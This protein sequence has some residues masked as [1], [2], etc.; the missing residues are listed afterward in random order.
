VAGILL[1]TEALIAEKPK[2]DKG[3]GG[4]ASKTSIESEGFL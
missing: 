2:D 3:M 4:M 1:T